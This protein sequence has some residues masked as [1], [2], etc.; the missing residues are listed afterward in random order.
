MAR[1]IEPNVAAAH[2]R[3][4]ADYVGQAAL[5]LA[6]MLLLTGPPSHVLSELRSQRE[7]EARRVP[8]AE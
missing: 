6:E 4:Q 5:C 1:H 2:Q 7:P 8:H 3:A